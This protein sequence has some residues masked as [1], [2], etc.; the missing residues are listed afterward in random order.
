MK[1]SQKDNVIV[2]GSIDRVP[3][4]ERDHSGLALRLG[5]WL[6]LASRLGSPL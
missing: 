2:R 6:R 3:E 5:D 1:D 4:T